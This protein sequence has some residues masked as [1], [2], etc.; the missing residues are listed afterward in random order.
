MIDVNPEPDEI[1]RMADIFLQGK[2]GEVLP[3]LVTALRAG[4]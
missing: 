2:G 3:Q 4:D 1:S